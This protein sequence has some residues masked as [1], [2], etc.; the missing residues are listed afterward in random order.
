VVPQA[1][2]K[3]NLMIGHPK[4]TK[5]A[6]A[7]AKFTADLPY[8]PERLEERKK[9]CSEMDPD[10][11]GYCSVAS[12]DAVL[13]R[14]YGF[15]EAQKM[16]L[17][18][19]FNETKNFSGKEKGAAGDYIE[20]KE[21]RVFLE[22]LCKK[23][24]MK[25]DKGT[26]FL[27]GS[28]VGSMKSFITVGGT[29]IAIPHPKPGKSSSLPD[30]RAK[31]GTV[32]E[33]QHKFAEM[34]YCYASMERKPLCPYDPNSQRNRLAIDDAPVPYKNASTIEFNDGIHVVHKNRFKTTQKT[35]F[36]GEPVD[37]TANARIFA[38]SHKVKRRIREM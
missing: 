25:I 4:A 31:F 17:I 6:A 2:A 29:I 15:G 11:N 28:K 22:T 35:D 30:L 36:N 5:G 9:L 16:Q 19:A 8:Q 10:G 26:H 3:E 32:S 24:G 12:V 37:M 27:S 13:R 34:P 7:S 18:H 20:H 38:H 33:S 21:F 23:L 1:P 14:K